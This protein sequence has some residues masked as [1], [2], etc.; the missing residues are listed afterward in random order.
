MS[1]MQGG[2][3]DCRRRRCVHK[4]KRHQDRNSSFSFLIWK[5]LAEKTGGNKIF[6]RSDIKQKS[7]QKLREKEGRS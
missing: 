6:N 4:D 3:C 1:Y 2:G 7:L 5:S